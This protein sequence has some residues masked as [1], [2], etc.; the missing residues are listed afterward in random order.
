MQ[1]ED[2]WKRLLSYGV[3]VPDEVQ[4]RVGLDMNQERV[5]IRPPAVNRKARVLEF[6]TSLPAT[7][8]AR[9]LGVTV[10]HVRRVRRLL[11]G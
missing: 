4:R 2:F 8:V 11:R 6:G 7:F 9:E 1:I 5:F 10:Q 3:V